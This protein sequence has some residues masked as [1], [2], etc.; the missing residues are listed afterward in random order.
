MA[1]PYKFGVIG[2]GGRGHGNMLEFL[3]VEGVQVTAICDQYADRVRGS[4][5]R[6][7]ELYGYRPA[8]Y[9]DYKELLAREDIGAVLVLL[10]VLV[11]RSKKEEK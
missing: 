1:E 9:T 2:L 3:K 5:N 8:E 10:G 4:A 6:V 11:R 7:E